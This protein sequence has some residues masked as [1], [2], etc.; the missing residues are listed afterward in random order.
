MPK[1]W[2]LEL[3]SKGAGDGGSFQ[4]FSTSL[5]A[6]VGARVDDFIFI[7]MHKLRRGAGLGLWLG[8]RIN[9]IFFASHE[10]PLVVVEAG[11]WFE[12]SIL[13]G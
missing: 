6:G 4:M 11:E 8:Y 12:S 13:F 2:G 9:A 7:L 3:A 5:R 1:R 10:D